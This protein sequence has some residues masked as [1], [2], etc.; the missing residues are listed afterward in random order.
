[1][2]RGGETKP[3]GCYSYL[4]QLGTHATYIDAVFQDVKTFDVGE[5]AVVTY[6][7]TDTAGRKWLVERRKPAKLITWRNSKRVDRELERLKSGIK[8]KCGDHFI[9]AKPRQ[10]S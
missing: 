3:V 5:R 9:E 8:N 7:I 10:E 1:M 6:L 2:L 4:P